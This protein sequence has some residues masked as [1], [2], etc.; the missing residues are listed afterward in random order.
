MR[1]HDWQAIRDAY[2]LSGVVGAA[3][4][5]LRKEGREWKGCCPFHHEKTPSFTINDEKQFFHCFG[6]SAHGDVI[7][8][9]VRTQNMEPA[10]AVASLT[11]GNPPRLTEADRAEREEWLKEQEQAKQREQHQATLKA[12]QRWERARP[13]EGPNAYL[14]LKGIAPF[15]CRVEGE[16]LLIPIDGPDGGIL[17]V[18]TISPEGAK[19]FQAGAPTVGGRLNIG[20]HMGRT[21]I[22]EGWATGQSLYEARADQVCVAFAKSNVS[23]IAR[24][25]AAAGVHIIIAADIDALDEM[26]ALGRELGVPVIAPPPLQAGKDFNDQAKEQGIE[27][28]A[29][30]LAQ[31]LIDY[32]NKPQAEPEPPFC[33]I[34]F[35]DAVDFDEKT[36][37]RR[38]W[39]IPGALMAGNTHILAAPGGTGKSLFTLQLAITLATGKTWGKWTPTKRC[40]VMIVNAEDDVAEQH[41]RVA[42]ARTVMGVADAEIRGRIMIADSPTSI[43]IAEMDTVK[44]IPK[45][46]ALVQQLVDMIRHHQVDALIVDPFAETFEGDENSNDEVKWAMKIWRDDIARATGCAVYLVHHVT[47]NSDEKAGSANAI[48]GAGALVNSVRFAATMFNM[49]PDQAGAMNVDPNDRFRYVRYDDAKSNHSL[50]SG[51]NWF[52]KVSVT[53][54]NGDDGDSDGGDEVG[55][56]RP[57]EPTAAAMMMY[58]RADMLALVKAIDDGFVTEDGEMTDDPFIRKNMSARWVGHVVMRFLEVE[59]KG[60]KAIVDRLVDDRILS[61]FAYMDEMK[62]AERKGLK[63]DLERAEKA[64]GP[65]PQ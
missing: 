57:W 37:E 63:V 24:E 8:F 39:L 31:G 20:I 38:K 45:A 52:E 19:R 7:D 43:A 60:V 23:V 40:K 46:S 26:N 1:G 22:C 5:K 59:R 54:Q 6:C 41:R 9:V 25:L 30:T 10:E 44:R 64:F 12:Q 51:T 3:G 36:I 47:K 29:A 58:P 2:P 14:D 33:S 15:G 42:A 48:R 28:V 34:S 56:L 53:L 65:P 50:I 4:V 18:Q 32:A 17:S 49:S 35:V 21:I 62:G 61:E 11:G 27:A 55:A 13:L 16:N